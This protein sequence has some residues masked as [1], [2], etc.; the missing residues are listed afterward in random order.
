MPPDPPSI[1]TDED[2]MNST[3]TSEPALELLP[4]VDVVGGRAVSHVGYVE[5][6]DAIRFGD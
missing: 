3:D 1:P 4:A 5:A 2:P 6:Y